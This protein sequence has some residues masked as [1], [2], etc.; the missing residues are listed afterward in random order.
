MVVY[1]RNEVVEEGGVVLGQVGA[2]VGHAWPQ[3]QPAQRERD[4]CLVLL[5]G[6]C[7]GVIHGA[8]NVQ[9]QVAG[10]QRLDHRVL[11][12]TNLALA[13]AAV[14]GVCTVDHFRLIERERQALCKNATRN[15][16]QTEQM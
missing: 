7:A 5:A 11:L 9:E 12:G 4:V 2:S 6:K 15:H 14:E 3:V 10:R 16:T 13:T 1:D 8:T